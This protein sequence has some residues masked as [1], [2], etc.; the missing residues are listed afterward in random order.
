M[1]N[2]LRGEKMKCHNRGSKNKDKAKFCHD[3]GNRLEV[4]KSE[5]K[6]KHK[7]KCSNCG[8]TESSIFWDY[9]DDKTNK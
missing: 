7:D 5:E 4:E 9:G 6:G 2:T 1:K 3:C 8:V